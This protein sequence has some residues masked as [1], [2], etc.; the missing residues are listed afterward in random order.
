M[1]LG[2]LFGGASYEHEISII[3][4][5][6]LKKKIEKDYEVHLLYVSLDGKYYNADKM[7]LNDFKHNQYKRLKKLKLEKLKLDVIVGA[8]H[9]E[10]GEDGLACAFA[11]IHNIKYLG[12][13]LFAGSLGLDKYRSYLY[14]A[15]NGVKMV[16]T[17]GYTY[18]DYL[19]N[20][21]VPYMPCIIKPVYGGSSLGITIAKTKEELPDKLNE[22]FEYSKEVI[23]EPYYE[24]LEEY[25][26]A[27]NETTFSCLEQIHK[28]D[29]I[30]SFENKYSDSFK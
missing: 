22:A 8:M 30:F 20:K 16:K 10:N 18:E 6:Q 24:E 9:G 25:N 4:A 1:K 27:L 23:I 11:K 26:L 7:Q 19:K 21:K 15:K 14:L 5:Y 2:I 3:T 29:D 28:K 17:I 13:D 12:C